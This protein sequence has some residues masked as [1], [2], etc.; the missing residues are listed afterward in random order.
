M[1]TDVVTRLATADDRTALWEW[2]R[3]PVRYSFFKTQPAVTKDQS[4]TWFNQFLTSNQR[5]RLYVVL[6]DII[7]IGFVRLELV[8]PDEFEATIFIRPP[9]LGK[10]FVPRALI[11]ATS[12]LRK[13]RPGARVFANVRRS[14]P[15]AEQLFASDEFFTE[16][17][18]DSAFRVNVI[19]GALR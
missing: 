14:T 5:T 1:V 6:V 10:G 11:S 12:E 15:Q 8:R 18:G 17:H 2:Y 13:H 16:P 9:Y 19:Q 3:D 7:R 4:R